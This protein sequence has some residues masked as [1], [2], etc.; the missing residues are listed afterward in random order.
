[1]NRTDLTVRDGDDHLAE[2]RWSGAVGVIGGVAED[3]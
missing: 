1:M 2:V 3:L